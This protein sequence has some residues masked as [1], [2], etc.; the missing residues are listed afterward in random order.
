VLRRIIE[1]SV[2][3]S[4]LTSAFAIAIVVLGAVALARTPVDAIPDLSDVQVIVTAELPGQAP[5]VVEDQ[6]TYP[7]STAMLA[8]PFAKTVRGLS[9]FGVSF[10]YVIFEDGTDLYWARSRVL[11]ALS[12]VGPRLPSG[13]AP[14]LGPDATGVGWIYEYALVDRSGERD[15]AELRALQDWFLRYEIQAIE[16]VAEV[17][18]VGGFVRQYQVEVDPSA[19]AAYGI[20]LSHV[21][22]AIERSNRDA[23]GGVIELAESEFMVRARGYVGGLD[24]L[25]AIAIGS[26]ANGTPILLRDVAS[27]HTGPELRRGATDLDGEGDV[28]AGIVVMRTG[29]NARA[30]IARV[31]E[32]LAEL[33]PGLPEGVEIVPVY[34]RSSLIDRSIENLR[35]KLV[36]ESV[37][38]ALVCALFLFHVRSALVAILTLPLGVLFSFIVMYAQ[39]ISANIMSLGGIAVAIGTMVDASIVMI[40]NAHKHLER[41]DGSKP[42]ARILLD[43]AGEVGPSL[44]FSLLIVTVSFL[45]VF[46]L[47]EQEGRLFRPLAYTKT[48]AMLGGALLSITV[49]PLFMLWLVRG[50]VRPEAANPLNRALHRAYGPVLRFAL[51]HRGVVMVGTLAV[52]LSAVVPV[53]RIGFEFMPP[54]DEGDLLYMPSTLP[55]VSIGKAREILQR[56]N[57]AILEVPEVA[58]VFG[59]VGRAETATDPAPLSMIETTVALR[60][61]AEWRPGL[62]TESLI[63]ELDSRVRMPGLSNAWTMPIRTRIDMLATGIRTPVGIKIA[64]PD[65]DVI[66]RLGAQVDAILRTI[67]G[68]QSVYAERTSSGNYLDIDIDRAAIARYGL[69]IG[70]V[71]DVVE[72]AIGGTNVTHT[73]EGL[74]RYPVSLRYQRELRDDLPALRRVL[75]ATP[76]GARV[77]LAQLASLELRSGPAEIRSENGRPNGWIHISLAGV[78]VGRYVREARDVLAREL[79]LPA[80]YSLT[81]SGQYEYIERATARLMIVVPLSLAL[82]FVLLHLNFGNATDSAIVMATVPFALVGGAWLVDLLDYDASIAVGVGFLALAGVA[83]ETGVVM[84]MFLEVALATARAEGRL[85]TREELEQAIFEGA[86]L[87]LRPKMMTV[88]TVFAGLLPIMWGAEAGSETMRRI[89]APMIGGMA[90]AT[91]LTLVVIPVVFA[92]VRGRK[93]GLASNRARNAGGDARP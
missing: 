2:A 10:V 9:F 93:L 38:V 18:S 15:Q 26:D 75:V 90:T 16:G 8:V 82:I 4:F 11:E 17:A 44:F 69:T 35:T 45:P 34:D 33:R 83:A 81:F 40:E 46:A 47:E 86:V 36:E 80:G 5:R 1:A 62:T 50:N 77:P 56:T 70:D 76:S 42:R 68:T 58:R 21:R 19:L 29:E 78:D 54:L 24:D 57:R 60:P 63:R 32:K 52:L 66:E 31:E 48:Y 65:L 7:L 73:V 28:A 43:A 79:E 27:V 3:N 13:V 39:G 51:R 84:L 55:G 87:R 64:G 25:R 91:V 53:A 71:Q 22:N 92:V 74:E 37:V 23:G 85:R 20:A 12:A 72:T 6:L 61:R 30:V 88:T 41:S 67:P 89:A 14:A 59:K 49:V